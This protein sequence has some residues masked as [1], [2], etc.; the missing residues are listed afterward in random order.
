VGLI[1]FLVTTFFMMF[2]SWKNGVRVWCLSYHVGNMM[3]WLAPKAPGTDDGYSHNFQIKFA[4]AAFGYCVVTLLASSITVIALSLPNPRMAHRSALKEMRIASRQF[5]SLLRCTTAMYT[6]SS[7]D[8]SVSLRGAKIFQ[9]R[10]V[11]SLG[12]LSAHIDASWWEHFDMGIFADVRAAL[13]KHVVIMKGLLDLTAS[14]HDTL[15]YGVTGEQHNQFVAEV[16]KPIGELVEATTDLFQSCLQCMADGSVNDEEAEALQKLVNN[17]E[18]SVNTL[19]SSTRAAAN[20][21]AGEGWLVQQKAL[22]SDWEFLFL[23]CSV[24]RLVADLGKSYISRERTASVSVISSV[25]NFNVFSG[26]TDPGHQ[27]FAIRNSISLLLCWAVGYNGL[28][29]LIPPYT[30]G[31]ASNASLLMS[32][33]VGSALKKNVGRVQGLV[34]GTT[35]GSLIYGG[36]IANGC[37][38]YLYYITGFGTTFLFASFVFYMFL[39]TTEYSFVFYLLAGFGSQKFLAKC[40]GE[41]SQAEMAGYFESILIAIVCV[42]ILAMVDLAMTPSAGEESAAAATSFAKTLSKAILFNMKD[43][44]I[45]KNHSKQHLE[46][47]L[48]TIR[49]KASEAEMEPHIFTMPFNGA[50][51]KQIDDRGKSLIIQLLTYRWALRHSATSTLE[52]ASEDLKKGDSRIFPLIQQCASQESVHDAFA[53]MLDSMGLTLESVVTAHSALDG[54][55]ANQDTDTGGKKVLSAINGLRDEIG[56]HI[57]KEKI[58]FVALDKDLDISIHIIFTVLEKYVRVIEDL[59]KDCQTFI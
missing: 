58:D 8:T 30:A 59:N 47:G 42:S 48:L 11:D 23:L 39:S 57:D 55:R 45:P 25:R 53:H 31:I 18:A 10:L 46:A 16:S 56:V 27:D 17:V 44:E 1:Y 7:V 4:G 35:L 28:F 40:T 33:A 51:F 50:L 24:S 6:D 3:A 29:S 12:G 54:F 14:L 49:E 36:I 26:F 9:D 15:E 2:G 13:N 52:G 5:E 22:K 37:D 21:F 38:T 20:K 32:T 19:S 41:P 34:V 43:C